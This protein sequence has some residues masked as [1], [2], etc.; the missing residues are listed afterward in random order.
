M[1]NAVCYAPG[2]E[3]D[4]CYS[5]GA[6]ACGDWLSCMYTDANKTEA[7]CYPLKLLGLACGYGVGNCVWGTSCQYDDPT[8]TTAH[9]Y[10][11]K[12][13]GEACGIGIGACKE[14]LYCPY[15]PWTGICQ[16]DPCDQEGKYGD[17]VCDADCPFTDPDCA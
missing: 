16:V 8:I 5:W 9:C 6:G 7:K 4:N 2:S 13:E 1:T 15:N 14:G 17:G 12:N 10:A 3:G 11:L